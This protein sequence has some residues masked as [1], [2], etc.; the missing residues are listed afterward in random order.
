MLDFDGKNQRFSTILRFNQKST[1]MKQL[2]SIFCIVFYLS[3]CSDK[4]FE[5]CVDV[6]LEKPF[7]AVVGKSY[8]LDEEN[9]LKIDSIDNQLCPCNVVCVWEGEMYIH[10]SGKSAGKEFLY[11]FGTSPHTP[12]SLKLRDHFIKL[13]SITPEICDFEIQDQFKLVLVA[14]R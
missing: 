3:S 4:S 2:F 10:F 12:D 1:N 13:K 5:E 8:C 14:E 7:I 6:S 9:Y 11:K